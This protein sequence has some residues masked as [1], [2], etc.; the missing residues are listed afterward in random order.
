MSNFNSSYDPTNWI[1]NTTPINQSNLNHVEQGIVAMQDR[2]DVL[3]ATKIESSYVDN[4]IKNVTF[5]DSTG[6]FTFTKYD[7]ST[8]T[9]D[10]LLEKVVVNFD[11]DTT[12]Q[13][14]VITMEDGTEKRVS[15]SA[16][17]EQD[18][19]QDS[20]TVAFTL[21][22][23]HIVKADIKAHS[24]GA[25]ELQQNYLADIQRE[26]ANAHTDAIRSRSYAVGDTNTRQD[27][28][29]DN[30]KYYKEQAEELAKYAKDASVIGNF[31]LDADG[32]LVYDDN[33]VHVF[34]I[35]ADGNLYYEVV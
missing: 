12:T 8:F 22:G 33:S 14:L 18:E 9:L 25:N 10:T 13:E 16:F 24:I 19:F 26:S 15:L 6:I 29:I 27:E 5:D 21:V 1:N 3:N 2:T 31:E 35:Q 17:I 20:D 4:A 11:Y 23:N 30:A 32:N 28:D 7:N 34:E